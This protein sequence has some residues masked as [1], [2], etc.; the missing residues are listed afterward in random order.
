LA[1]G[2]RWVVR[3]WRRFG[4]GLK[5]VAVDWRRVIGG[6]GKLAEGYRWWRK[7]GGGLWVVG[8]GL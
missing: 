2:W 1:E 3:G 5:V 6:G 4:R 8:G 7:V